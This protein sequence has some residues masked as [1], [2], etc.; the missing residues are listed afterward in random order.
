MRIWSLIAPCVPAVYPLGPLVV[1][2]VGRLWC[3]LGHRRCVSLSGCTWS[4]GRLRQHK[5]TRRPRF[6]TY[7]V[8]EAGD[9][10]HDQVAAFNHSFDTNLALDHN[11][12]GTYVTA[13]VEH[14]SG[15]PLPCSLRD[16]PMRKCSDSRGTMVGVLDW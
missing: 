8:G 2:S 3:Q 16:L 6:D 13:L 7:L 14:L 10:W 1:A 15:A 9:D 12:C 4:A 11:D 5:F